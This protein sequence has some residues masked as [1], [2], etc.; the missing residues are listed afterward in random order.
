MKKQMLTVVLAGMMLVQGC[1]IVVEL[2][3]LIKDASA[4]AADPGRTARKKEY[5]ARAKRDAERKTCGSTIHIIEKQARCELTYKSRDF[6]IKELKGKA[7]VQ[8]WSEGNLYDKISQLPQGGYLQIKV[9][10]STIGSAN[11]KYWEYVVHSIEGEE[12]MRKCGRDSIPNYTIWRYLTV[13]WNIDI[14]PI[15]WEPKGKFKVYI[16]DTLLNKRSEF[17][18]YPNQI[19]Y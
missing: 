5:Q 18:V 1:G 7:V 12:L 3:T 8:L 9:K 4:E 19:I 14:L 2:A 13:W 11:T 15:N 16:I 10:G 6:L 17:I